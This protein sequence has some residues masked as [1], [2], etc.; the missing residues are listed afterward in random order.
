MA[1]SRT[2]LYLAREGYRKRRLVDA[3]R[4]LPVALFVLLVLPLLWGGE[5]TGRPV[6]DGLNA[7]IHVFVVWAIGITAMVF[8]SI[9][10]RRR[11]ALE[12]E[13]PTAQGHDLNEGAA[14]VVA[15]VPRDGG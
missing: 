13:S 10:L 12:A 9:A 6:G 2:P 7:V 4:I 8:L 11:D 5:G 1:E 3:Q 14:D 15:G